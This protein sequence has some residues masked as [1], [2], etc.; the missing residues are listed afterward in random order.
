MSL[1]LSASR[2]SDVS[3]RHLSELTNLKNLSLNGVQLSDTAISHL[4]ALKS[5][6][7]LQLNVTVDRTQDVEAKLGVA[8]PNCEIYL[9]GKAV[10]MNGRS[11]H[12]VR[13]G[14]EIT[15]PRWVCVARLTWLAVSHC[16]QASRCHAC[17][18]LG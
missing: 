18:Q 10:E 8:L 4:S 11:I 15:Y 6:G 17:S 3:L 12:A 1:G 5:L 16:L 7:Q 14:Q 13:R 9:D 2:L